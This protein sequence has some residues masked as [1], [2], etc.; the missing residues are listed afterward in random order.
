MNVV[1]PAI[2]AMQSRE[3]DQPAQQHRD[4]ETGK[5]HQGQRLAAVAVA[6]F[7]PVGRQQNPQDC[8][9]GVSDRHPEIGDSNLAPDRRHHRL[10]RGIAGRRDKHRG[11]KKQ[12][13]RCAQRGRG[14]VADGCGGGHACALESRSPE[15]NHHPLEGSSR[16]ALDS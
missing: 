3:Q 9:P 12:E 5:P 16:K 10:Q 13:V 11:I 6:L 4:D 7:R 15:R 2:A 14:D 1:A 8:R